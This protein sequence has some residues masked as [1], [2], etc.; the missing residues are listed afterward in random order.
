MRFRSPGVFEGSRC[1]VFQLFV[2]V[3]LAL[4]AN[5]APALAQGN[6]DSHWG[7]SVSLSPSW[8]ANEKWQELLLVEGNGTIEGSEMTVGL[9]R[10]STLGGDWGVS[11]VKKSVKDGTTITSVD[12]FSSQGFFDRTTQTQVLRDVYFQ[13][14]EGHVFIPFATI[15]NRVQ[16]G[17]NVGGGIATVKGFVEET[18]EFFSQFTF[19][20][21]QVQTNI[22]R[23]T[24][25]EEASEVFYKYQPLF[26]LEAQGA[27]IV[28]PAVK[29]K[30]SGGFNAPSGASFRI[31][32]VF[33]IGAK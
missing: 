7:A 15:K 17:L 10:G 33:L 12:E 23:E 20:N 5:A 13:G 26:K 21:G 32:A 14:V 9:I 29:V 30:I 27:I 4:A 28:V 11:F 18:L 31:G 6:K 2:V 24:F 25:T 1:R 22:N 3:V 16:V 19:P 8:K